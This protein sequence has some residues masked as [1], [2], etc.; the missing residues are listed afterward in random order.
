MNILIVLIICVR[1][2]QLVSTD[3]LTMCVNVLMVSLE[4]IVKHVIIVI[5]KTAVLM[6]NVGMGTL[7]ILA[8]VNRNTKE[9]TVN[10]ETTV[11][12]AHVNTDYAQTLILDTIAFVFQDIQEQIVTGLIIAITNIAHITVPVISIMKITNANVMAVI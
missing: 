11:I 6:V 5:I 7:L 4:F 9:T 1:M 10:L 3:T 12:V 2:A 8:I